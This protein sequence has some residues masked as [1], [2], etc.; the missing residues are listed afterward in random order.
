VAVTPATARLR[1]AVGGGRGFIGAAVCR[2]LAA[3]GHDAIA[4][5]REG[6]AAGGADVLV[7]AGGGREPDPAAL[8][9]VHVDAPV[10]AARVLAP[11]AIVYLSSA[12]LYGGAPVPFREDGPIDPRTPY[13]Q[14]KRDGELAIAAAAPRVIVLRPGVVYGPGQPER[15]LFAKVAAAL[16]A[17]A[18]VALSPGDQTRDFVWIDD[19]AAL[20]ARAALADAPAGV[21][22][23]GT[24]REVSV[25][26]A[27]LGIAAALGADRAALLDFGAQPY[28]A[29]EQM[30]YALDPARAAAALGWRATVS[31]EDGLARLP[32]PPR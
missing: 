3:A 24:G 23:A 18:R 31:L 7:W 17:G 5:G 28:R 22:N 20:V 11:R 26:D 25:R 1:V 9:A 32:A 27:C 4:F 6:A 13:A 10:A 8:R 14:A 29:G 19:V 12:E 15:M 16:A 2:A 21:Y 30:R